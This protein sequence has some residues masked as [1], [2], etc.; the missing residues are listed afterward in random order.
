MSVYFQYKM[1]E[2]F[3]QSGRQNC[4]INKRKSNIKS[5]IFCGGKQ[6]GRCHTAVKKRLRVP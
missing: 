6:T 4:K 2:Q 3:L 1:P 5:N